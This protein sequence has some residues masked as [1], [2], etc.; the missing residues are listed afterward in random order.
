MNIKRFVT[1]AVLGVSG[2]AQADQ[3]AQDQDL[4]RQFQE[5]R[6]K[7]QAQQ[8][9]LEAQQSQIESQADEIEKLRGQA[10]GDWLT[11][12]RAEEIRGLV[13]DVLVDA[14]MRA[15][16]LQSGATSG[17]DGKNFFI[18]T[19]DGNFL[20]KVGGQIQPRYIA[21]F[22]D[23][24]AT[25]GA[26]VPVDDNELG[27]QIRR[28]KFF[29]D[30]HLFNPKL[31]Y[32]MQAAANRDTGGLEL[33][34]GFIAYACSD[35]LKVLVGRFADPL[36][37]DSFTSNSRQL[38][39]ERSITSYV[40][41]ANDNYSEGVAAD[42][43]PGEAWRI[44][45]SVNDGIGSGNPGGTGNDFASDTTDFAATGR[46]DWRVTGNWKQMDDFSAWSGEPTALFLGAA[47]HYELA[48]SGDG[49]VSAPLYDDF[50]TYTV[51]GSVEAGG[52]NVFA[53][54]IGQMV[55]TVGGAADLDNFGLLVQAGYMI[56]PDKFEPFARY[57]WVDIDTAPD[58]LNI[59][60]AGL[61][62]YWRA[63][64]M[65]FTA[66]VVYCLDPVTSATTFG[67]TGSAG[68]SLSGMGLLADNPAS[69]GQVSLRA[70]FQLLF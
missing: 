47:V 46:V 60:T 70:Q 7:M 43:R 32:R 62:Y 6:D 36:L 27:F 3:A 29:F 55:N 24:T 14:D 48:E 61:N 41:A 42:W 12:Q 54:G 17:H 52:L 25:G 53:A 34:E 57:E 21:N 26:G 38:A 67:A 50:I 22:R 59:I 18:G 64:A 58:S 45:G 68:T 31:T 5:L 10:P 9:T 33:E 16:L 28:V 65:K 13:A 44:R 66:D 40:F 35:E 2:T 15:S 1:L 63:H 30:G 56:V 8:A 23:D 69:D 39:V 49:Q 11:E 4:A 20:L 51:D 19:S 37:R